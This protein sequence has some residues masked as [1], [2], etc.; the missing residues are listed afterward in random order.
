GAAGGGDRDARRLRLVEHERRDLA[1]DVGIV[2]GLDVAAVARVRA[3]VVPGLVV[4][5][6]DAEELHLAVVDVVAEGRDHALALVLP[7]VAPAGREGH[8]RV[9]VV[10]VDEHVH[11]PP[12]AVAV[13]AMVLAMHPASWEGGRFYWKSRYSRASAPA[14]WRSRVRRASHTLHACSTRS[15]GFP[16][17]SMPRSADGHVPRGRAL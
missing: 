15:A 7:L 14:S 5:G 11:V 10:A 3:L 6:V 17:P 13:P 8:D 1:G 2:H 4:D 12:E 9:A 16:A